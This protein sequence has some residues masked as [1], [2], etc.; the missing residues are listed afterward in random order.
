[1]QRS[2]CAPRSLRASLCL[3][4][5]LLAVACT[6]TR[7]STRDPS[8]ASGSPITLD[9]PFPS[10]A[11]LAEIAARPAPAPEQLV[12]RKVAAADA[13]ALHGPGATETSVRAYAGT[14][15]NA[16]AL[17][18][19]VADLGSGHRVTSGM[20]CFAEELG[21]FV[22]AHGDPPAQDVEAFIAARCGTTV[23]SPRSTAAPEGLLPPGG[24]VLPRD[25]DGLAKLLSELPA[26]AELGVW[27]GHEG[28]QSMQVVAFGVPE[29]E[30]E[31]VPM[32]SGSGGFVELR[33]QVAWDA[34]GLIGYATEGALG[35]ATCQPLPGVAVAPPAFALRCPVSPQDELAV[36][37]LSAVPRGRLLGRTVARVLVSPRGVAPTAYQAPALS[38][39]V[40]QGEHDQTAVITAVNAVRR[41]AG[42][43]PVSAAAGQTDV[44]ESLAPHLFAAL[45]DPSQTTLV[46]QITLGLMAGRKVE[47]NVRSGQFSVRASPH[48]WSLERML[49]AELSS[50]LARAQLLDPHTA[51]VAYAAVADAERG[52][53]RS[54]L[55]GYR[56]FVDRDYSPEIAAFFDLVDRQR[57]VRGLEP[58]IRVDAEEDRTLLQRTAA[59]VRDGQLD[60]SAALDELL[61]HYA[62]KNHRS[63]QGT[64]LLPYELQGWAPELEG[65][66]VTAPRVAAAV[67]VSHWEPPGSAWGRQLVLVVFT[68]L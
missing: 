63:F 20:Q 47:G 18:A 62:E 45:D 46:D 29:V 68:V 17:A 4:A 3:A 26:G 35:F 1:M 12:G 41:R 54:L 39:P 30:L 65:D 52:M 49:A 5:C 33:G 8:A 55:A 34:E 58:V 60:P 11:A 42:L 19:V 28:K 37:E 10:E 32:A 36:L 7:T 16:K 2:R 43:Q 27:I 13:W 23:V 24:L 21:R 66:L 25:F 59:R 6:P 40:S 44:V 22:L 50:P 61:A 38:L 53:R 67:A 14:D 57:V 31:P 56:L 9:D 51:T 64:V 15:P 48:A